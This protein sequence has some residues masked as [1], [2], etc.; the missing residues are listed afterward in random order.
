MDD[1][2][3]EY[4]LVSLEATDSSLVANPRKI[5]LKNDVVFILDRGMIFQFSINGVFLS[6]L[7][8]RGRG[9]QEYLGI[10][11]FC[12]S[13]EEI[14]IWDRKGKSLFRYSLENKY[15][16]RY[17]LDNYIATI[18]LLDNNKVLFLSAY[19]PRDEYKFIIRDLETMDL[20][21]SFY[22]INKA[23]ISYR[24]FMGQ[25]NYYMYN[26]TLLFHEPMNNY[27]YKIE[28]QEFKPIYYI[29]IFGQNPPDKFWGK[30]YKNIIDIHTI[31][32]NKGY[33]YGIPMYAESDVQIIF[34]FFYEDKY[35]LCRY[36]KETG[37]S[38]QPET[39][40]LFRTVPALKWIDLHANS[41][42]HVIFSIENSVFFDDHCM[43]YV[44]ELSLLSNN[45]NPV[46]CI[47]KLK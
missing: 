14:I 6:V 3:S 36:L 16:N 29:D 44:K 33:R 46:I 10:D 23:Q 34:S 37:E 19:E 42:D 18:Y 28:N 47:A 8:R 41:E 45:D 22:P 7:D 32:H 12:I 2:F 31:A 43:P 13:D 26:G 39:I 11:D 15:I 9:P 1:L 40:I 20:I 30:K 35:R 38:V 4:T 5:I 24:H 21:A 25:E 27:I 17:K